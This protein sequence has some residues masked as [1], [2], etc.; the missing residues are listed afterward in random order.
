MPEW[1]ISYSGFLEG[2]TGFLG[3]WNL[4]WVVLDKNS[5]II[6]ADE[7]EAVAKG[8]IN[9]NSSC[10]VEAEAHQSGRMFVFSLRNE[11]IPDSKLIFSAFDTLSIE[12][13]MIALIQV[14]YIK[15]RIP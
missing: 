15:F 6:F 5:L 7:T 10:V 12:G 11:T 9:I 3:S 2:K 14:C 1:D 13:W 4:Y 8:K